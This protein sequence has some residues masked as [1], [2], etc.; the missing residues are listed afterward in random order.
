MTSN[1]V[2]P[3]NISCEDEHSRKSCISKAWSA[4]FSSTITDSVEEVYEKI[5]I[6][7][8]SKEE[9][10]KRIVVEGVCTVS[11][12]NILWQCVGIFLGMVAVLVGFVFWPTDNVFLDPQ[13]WYQCVLQCGFVWIG[14][15]FIMSHS[16]QCS[17]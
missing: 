17:L 11:V 14:Q 9:E 10:I 7:D 3:L 16:Y 2:Q 15:L 6:K 8:A 5:G 12:W 4:L 1:K 13:N